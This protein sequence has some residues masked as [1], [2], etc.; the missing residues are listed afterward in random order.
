M[1]ILWLINFFF[2]VNIF[3][4]FLQNLL[5]SC[6]VLLPIHYFLQMELLCFFWWIVQIIQKVTVNHR[7]TNEI[8]SEIAPVSRIFRMY[9]LW[10]EAY[11]LSEKILQNKVYFVHSST[12]D[13]F[14]SL[15][16]RTAKNWSIPK[17]PGRVN[18]RNM[19]FFS[20]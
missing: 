7:D 13:T 20:K 3:F 5:K 15:N 14:H 1:I 6:L 16:T 8:R 10:N 2:I 11:N 18:W 12:L 19:V 4:F 9:K 17:R